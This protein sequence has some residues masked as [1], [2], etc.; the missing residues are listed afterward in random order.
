M[1]KF[2][3]K[4]PE[5]LVTPAGHRFRILRHFC[6]GCRICVEFCPTGTLDLDDRFKVKVAHPEKCVACRMCELRCP[7]LAIYVTRAKKQKGQDGAE[8]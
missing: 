2:L 3:L 8:S 1:K 7:D 5:E 4:P 6:K